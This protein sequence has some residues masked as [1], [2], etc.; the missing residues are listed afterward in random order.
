MGVPS[1][2]TVCRGHSETLP[3]IVYER[4]PGVASQPL[5]P[6]AYRR[7]EPEKTVLYQVV[8]AHLETFLAQARE[9]TDSGT[10]CPA[11]V[12]QQFRRFLDCG[13]LARGF[14]RIK[15][16]T[17]GLERFV[18]LSCGSRWCCACAARRAADIAAHL[19]DRVLP[20]APYRQFVLTFPRPLL[21]LLSVDRAFMTRMLG[22]Y[23]KTLFAWQ[24]WRGRKA[25]IQDGQ[26]G[27]VTF[28]QRFSSALSIFP[29]LHSLVPDGLL[30][31]APGQRLAFVQLPPPTDQDIEH[32]LA[33]LVRRLT[34]IARGRMEQAEHECPDDEQTAAHATIAEA[35]RSPVPWASRQAPPVGA[36]TYKPLCAKRDGFSLHAARAVQASNRAALEQLCRYGLRGPFASERFTL[37]PDGRVRYQLGKPGSDGQAKP[38]IVLEPLPLLRRLAALV[39]APFGNLI[40]Y[41]GVFANRSP[42]RPLL[43]P[44]PPSPVCMTV[45]TDTATND[46]PSGLPEP[47]QPP[48]CSGAAATIDLDTATTDAPIR[49]RKLGWAQLLRRTLGVDPLK[50]ARCGAT[51]VVLALIT[52]PAIVV[53]ILQHLGLPTT[54][55]PI[56]P[57]R[58]PDDLCPDTPDDWPDDRPDDFGAGQSGGPKPSRDPPPR[59]RAAA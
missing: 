27:A 12:E 9:Q 24:R 58:L 2:R 17:C 31:A 43:P 41:H 36:L 45:D 21:F 22:A 48:P 25:G 47:S 34:P 33:R 6:G 44:P 38:D 3:T 26:T 55:P 19:V 7:R 51:M 1:Q 15:C 53:R 57:A 42:W 16:S 10:G 56:A 35:L 5:P 20:E 59:R 18:A 30:V 29:H 11:F 46:P 23:L 40:R 8:Q 39:P 14:T 52:Q 4:E 50:C 49:P 13:Q 37:D 28:V 54:V 32:L